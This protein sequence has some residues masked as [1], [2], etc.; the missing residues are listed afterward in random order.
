MTIPRFPG[1][2]FMLALGQ[3]ALALQM[4]QI[5]GESTRGQPLMA[6]VGL[7]GMPGAGELGVELLPVHGSSRDALSRYG[8]Q[9]RVSDAA[10]AGQAVVVTSSQP[11]DFE[12]LALRLR[13]RDGKQSLVRHFELTIPA[14]L[15]RAERA[16]PTRRATRAKAATTQ[17]ASPATSIVTDGEYGPVRAGQTL[18]GIVKETGLAH[19]GDG[20]AL[21]RAIVAANPAA[22]V[23]GDAA[24]LRVGARLRLPR[25]QA[26]TPAAVA[27][28]A[29]AAPQTVDAETA[30]RLA[31]LAEKFEQ[32]RA[33]YAAQQARTAAAVVLA[34][35]KPKA[36]SGSA[37]IKDEQ[38]AAAAE[39][40]V[41]DAVPV[42]A[43]VTAEATKTG[44]AAAAIKARPV[45]VT[46]PPTTVT[47][48][49]PLDSLATM[50]DGRILVAI[51]T[52]LLLVALTLGALRFGRRM[53]ARLA[54]GGERSAERD[55][56][57]EISRKTEKRVQ[58]ED[59]VK[60]MIAGRIDANTAASQ[61]LLRP[62]DLLA[63]V[64]GSLE[65]IETRIAH[66]QYNE[67]E[68]MLEQ[69][70]VDAPNNFR[71]KLRLAEI[72]Y[73]NERHEEFVDLAE[74]IHRQHRSDIGDENWAR[75]MRMGKVIAP[76]RPPFSGP[77]AVEAGRRAH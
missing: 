30:A 29:P 14:P 5:T 51:G 16:T 18:W 56:L 22:F 9:A 46:A 59:E 37:P 23:G 76:D 44:V 19:G 2:L 60:R 39:S 6:R 28:A 33:R 25:G 45:P 35:A 26:A 21:M 52:L 72:Y 50:V 62:A 75:L 27:P 77:V 42:P 20:Q 3:D 69:T 31:R 13:L 40:T 64:R 36:S 8:L 73:L 4:G 55:M 63:G 71:A 32:I 47:D 58:L 48:D 74:E 57:A 54:D 1:L 66:G 53:R 17:P 7:Y 61:G 65:E 15:A 49:S 34:P 10:S 12:V 41:V 24:R 70:I 67:A 43:P 11:I 68:A 38:Q